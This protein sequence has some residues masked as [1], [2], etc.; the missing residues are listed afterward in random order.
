MLEGRGGQSKGPHPVCGALCRAPQ[1]PTRAEGAERTSRLPPVCPGVP[2]APRPPTAAPH[3]SPRLSG[4]ARD[5]AGTQGCGGEAEG[6][7]GAPGEAVGGGGTATL[8]SGARGGECR[9]RPQKRPRRGCRR[10]TSSRRRQGSVPKG[11]PEASAGRRTKAPRA[12][13]TPL[14]DSL[15]LRTDGGNKHK[16]ARKGQTTILERKQRPLYGV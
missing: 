15:N 2:R 5:S 7:A 1:E 3:S 14:R 6:Q 4:A 10:R 16:P 11:H 9:C 12:P 8:P 13:R